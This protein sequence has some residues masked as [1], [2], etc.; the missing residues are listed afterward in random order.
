[1]S[2]I[3][4][5]KVV[6][7]PSGRAVYTGR[8]N[9][10][11]RRL[12]EHGNRSSGC[13]LIRDAI[14]SEG[15]DC[16]R[17][18]PIVRCAP[19]DADA[20]ESHY[21]IINGT[22]HPQGYNLCHGSTAGAPAPGERRM[23]PVGTTTVVHFDG[24]A[25]EM[26][27]RGE[28]NVAFA[29]L[30]EEEEAPHGLDDVQKTVRRLM[31][32]VHP[33]R[34]GERSFSNSEVLAMLQRVRK[35]VSRATDKAA[36]KRPMPPAARPAKQPRRVEPIAVARDAAGPSSSGPAMCWVCKDDSCDPRIA[37]TF[38]SRGGRCNRCFNYAMKYDRERTVQ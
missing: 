28:A 8:S 14:R 5:Y 31:R 32:Q 12:R 33:D 6:H 17:V 23:Q 10:P 15:I 16:F 37:S 24:P 36:E 18:E 4:I 30:C 20:N 13:R 3:T 7:I 38:L 27:A 34:A 26:R 2:L 29:E 19:E 1:M 35:S 25:D 21:I 9:D 22:M 11:H